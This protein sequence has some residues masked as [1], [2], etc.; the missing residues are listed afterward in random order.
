MTQLSFSRA[1][2]VVFAAVV[3]F[4]PMRAH[5]DAAKAW[6]AA[7]DNLPTSTSV[8][9]GVNLTTI[10][11]SSLFTTM[12]PLLLAQQHD[13]KQALDVIKSACHIDPLT[14]IHGVVVGTDADQKHGAIYIAVSG[15]DQAKLTSCV[16]LAAKSGAK[17]AK[18][19]VTKDGAITELAVDKDKLYLGWIGSDVVVIPLD[20]KDKAQLQ[21]WMGNKGGFARSEV[22]K[23]TKKVNTAA[24]A[25]GVS[26][27]GRD[28]DGM[29]M[30]LG[31]GALTVGNGDLG[32]DLH[33][34]VA[35]AKDAGTAVDKAHKD[36]AGIAIAGQMSPDLLA[37]LKKIKVS[38]KGE[39][40][41]IKLT[42]AE[43]QVMTVFGAL[44]GN[45]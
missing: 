2:A 44:L 17:D 25:W 10:T 15:I 40:V 35:T 30:K 41:V 9:I 36:L 21:S 3:L 7:R 37:I 6:A 43:A 8:L 11:N 13:V 31:Y 45:N 32:L 16:E 4:V 5:A 18:L 19:T 26:A 23:A 39:E 33:V 22:A 38:A 12:F 20:I 14:A 34:A 29:K 28:L 42:V 27:V 1:R 24:A